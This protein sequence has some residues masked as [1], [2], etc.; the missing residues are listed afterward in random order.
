MFSYDLFYLLACFFR[1]P[2]VQLF[3]LI[4]KFIMVDTNVWAKIILEILY[5]GIETAYF[6][7]YT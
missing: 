6:D 5:F 7:G 4:L 2:L 1:S 3:Y